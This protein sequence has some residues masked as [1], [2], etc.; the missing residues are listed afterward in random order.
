M[1]TNKI[2][3]FALTMFIGG[4][5]MIIFPDF[6]NEG[7]KVNFGN[8][9]TVYAGISFTFIGGVILLNKFYKWYFSKKENNNEK[10]NDNASS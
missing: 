5:A 1:F 7:T 8:P 4:I 2:L 9:G 10:H 6:H 3:E